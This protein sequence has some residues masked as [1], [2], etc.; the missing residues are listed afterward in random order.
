TQIIGLKFLNE[1]GSGSTS[2]ALKT[3]DFAIQVK[4]QGL[5]DIRVLSNSWGGGG[6]SQALLDQ[7][8]KAGDNGMLFVVAAGN[9]NRSDDRYAYYPADYQTPYK[10]AIAAT[11]QN[12]NKASFSSYGK[13]NVSLGAPGV[14]IYSTTINHTTL[15]PIYGYLSGTS[16]ATP[17]V[18]GAAALVLSKCILNPVELKQNLMDS[19]DPVASMDGIT[20]TGGRL[21]VAKAIQICS[22]ITPPTPTPVTPTPTPVTPTPTPVTPTPTPVTPTPTPVTPTPTPVTPTPTI[23]PTPPPPPEPP[24]IVGFYATI[25]KDG[26]PMTTHFIDTSIGDPDSWYWT[27][28]DGTTSTER[29]PWHTFQKGVH[30]VTLTISRDD[31]DLTMSRKNYIKAVGK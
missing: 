11:D 16:M 10:M 28:G 1:N 8:N 24:F 26:P 17:H 4:Q 13:E 6:F 29:N 25:T 14:S 15:A 7:I 20:I 9:S 22:G 23:P 3:L 12:D 27:F 2:N 5:A 30:T 21:N 19:V 31:M 18:A